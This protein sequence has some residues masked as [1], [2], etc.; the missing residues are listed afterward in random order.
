MRH[1]TA[2]ISG[3][4]LCTPYKITDYALDYS[5]IQSYM[6]SGLL[7]HAGLF[8]CFRFPHLSAMDYN[9]LSVLM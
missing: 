8:E 9:V 7:V 1:E 5:V 6:R 2:A 4:V 3:H